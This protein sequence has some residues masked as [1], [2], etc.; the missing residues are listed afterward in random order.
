MLTYALEVPCPSFRENEK[1]DPMINKTLDKTV[2]FDVAS[3]TL[4]TNLRV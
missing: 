3:V 4:D 1:C 2:G